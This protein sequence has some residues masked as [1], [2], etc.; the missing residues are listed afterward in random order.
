MTNFITRI[1]ALCFLSL[2]L[3]AHA[4]QAYAADPAAVPEIKRTKSGL[5]VTAREAYEM[6]AANPEKVLFLDIRT[7]SEVEFLGMPTLADANVPYMLR[8]EWNEW[9]E[10]KHNFKLEVNAFFAAEVEKRLAQKGLAKTDP[11][12]L[13]CRSGDRSAKA[14]DLLSD[15]GYTSVYSV[16]DGFEGDLA[17]EGPK[18]GQRVVNGWKNADLPWSYTLEREK[19]YRVGQ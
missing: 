11:V 2:V 18:K 5:Y 8:S 14:A 7:P 12:V 10:K 16:V 4:L 17:R 19:M 9:D 15:L 3:A 13:I 6:V 1:R